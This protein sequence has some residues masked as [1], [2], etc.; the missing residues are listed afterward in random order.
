ML[1]HGMSSLFMGIFF[2][3][4]VRSYVVLFD[5]HGIF[6]RLGRRLY[7]AELYL[8]YDGGCR[9]CR[10]T[11]A[12]VRVL[13][14]FER[15]T[16]V[17]AADQEARIA[18]GLAGLDPEAILVDMHAVV[19]NKIDRG[20]AA[21]RALARRVP[22]LWP[23]LP[24]L[25][26]WPVPSIGE[27]IYRRVADSRACRI[28][29]RALASGRS[30]PDA[31][32]SRGAALAV[33]GVILVTANVIFGIKEEAKAWP[34]ACYPT[35]ADRKTVPEGQSLEVSGLSSGGDRVSLG[36]AA[37]AQRFSTP[38]WRG[39]LERV[40]DTDNEA[41]RSRR[42]RALWRVWAHDDVTLQNVHTVRFYRVTLTTIPEQRHQNPLSRELLWEL[43][44]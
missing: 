29:D 1:F 23:I 18:H 30:S 44:Q 5:W 9:L 17:E 24:F 11:I 7:P 39:L 37:L 32:A 26:L 38:R 2:H 3:S 10:R 40:L 6:T 16:Y 21:Y 42:F 12:T 28:T 31:P 25:Y 35:F 19:A 27:S 36:G 15:V 14:V 22:I 8:V 20:Y 41:E 43:R 4:L 33:I 13:D 34:F